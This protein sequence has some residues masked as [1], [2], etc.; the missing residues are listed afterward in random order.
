MV[1]SKSHFPKKRKI[2]FD[3]A[4]KMFD[5]ESDFETCKWISVL[6][7]FDLHLSQQVFINF[8][9]KLIEITRKELIFVM[10]TL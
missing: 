9:S 4:I 7:L 6:S 1:F 3:K 2:E 10:P 8:R 5:S